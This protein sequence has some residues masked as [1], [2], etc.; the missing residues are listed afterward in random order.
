MSNIITTILT[1]I[2]AAII[3]SFAPKKDYSHVP[4]EY[5]NLVHFAE[6]AGY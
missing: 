4:K 2:A 3:L 6:S 5:R 1:L